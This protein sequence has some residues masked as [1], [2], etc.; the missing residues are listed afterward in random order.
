MAFP[1]A[2][3]SALYFSSCTLYTPLSTLINLFSFPWPPSLCGWHSTIFLF[4]PIQL[5]LKHFSPS[6]R[7]PRN[8]FLG[9]SNLRLNSCSSDSIINLQK[10]T[11]LHFTPPNLLEILASSMTNILPSLAKLHL[12]PKPVTITFVS[13]AVSG[14]TSIRQLPVSLLPLSF[15]P[16]LITAILL[17]INSVSL[18]YPV[19]GRYKTFLLVLSLKLLSPVMSLPSHALSIAAGVGTAFSRMCLSVCLSVCPRSNRKTAW[20]INIKL[21]ARTL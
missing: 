10:Y 20:A 16:N 18:N 21:G 1:K 8:L 3:F 12:S 2:L 7:S 17:T 11:T 15:T 19:S 4:S 6:K 9:D 14:L 5:W 13:L